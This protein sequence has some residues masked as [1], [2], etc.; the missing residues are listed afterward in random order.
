MNTSGVQSQNSCAAGSPG[1]RRAGFTLT[2]LVVVLAIVAIVTLGGFMAMPDPRSQDDRLAT[3]QLRSSLRYAQNLAVCRERFVRVAFN[4]ASNTY[5]VSIA[6]GNPPT[7][8]VAVPHPVK[9]T[10]WIES[11]TEDFPD[12][13]LAS[14]AIGGTNILLFNGTNGV[15]WNASSGS[16]S[17]AT[18]IVTF[19]S[20][21][22]VNIFP[23]TGYVTVQ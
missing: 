21:R 3:D 2:Q 17:T 18:G 1:A 20:G 19:A 23:G 15:P 6:T 9:Q 22:Q 7:A 8:Y 11:F 5:A 13:R 16:A 4:V 14:A 12:A 10:D